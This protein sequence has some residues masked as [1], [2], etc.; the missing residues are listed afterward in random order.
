MNPPQI[1]L[2]ESKSRQDLAEMFMRFQEYY[3]SPEFKGKTFSVDDFAHWYATKY[4]SFSYSRDWYGFNIPGTVLSP[5]LEGKFDPLTKQEQK[6][7]DFCKNARGSSY[8]IGT[9]PSSEYFKETIKHEFVHG[10]FYTNLE[11]RKEVIDCI[12]DF[13]IK[14]IDKGLLKMG[15]CN[16]VLI[17]ET[18]AY[19]LVEPNTIQEYASVNNTKNLRDN[20]DKIFVKY[21]RFSVL[22]TEIP[23][24]MARTEH[25]LV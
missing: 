1:Y 13:C 18:N 19:V 5:F 3:E 25:I 15:Y 21:F 11:Y 9:T 16:E 8:I 22:K 23:A 10:V 2:I 17:D 4:G 6:L 7:V 14:P 20:L 24:L 12:K